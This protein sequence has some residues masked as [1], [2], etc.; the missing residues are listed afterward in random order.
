[1]DFD[2]LII[3]DWPRGLYLVKQLNAKGKKTAYLEIT[4]YLKKP[5]PLFLDE[6]KEKNFLENLGFL[7]FQEEGF[8]FLSPEGVRFFKQK[9]QNKTQ[10]DLKFKTSFLKKSFLK[11]NLFSYLGQNLAGRVF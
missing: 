8:C 3:A 11:D 9:D 7:S 5:F 10:E 6:S 1:M 4:P 2:S